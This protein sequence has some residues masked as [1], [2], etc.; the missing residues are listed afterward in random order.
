[1][2]R[3][4]DDRRW[5]AKAIELSRRCPPSDTAFSVGA[6]IVDAD[7]NE[8]ATGYSRDTDPHVHAEESALAKLPPDDP[9]LTS[10]TL[11]STLEPCTQRRSRPMPCTELILRARI[12]RIVIAWRE[13]A[14]F[15][16][17]CTG[18]ETLR[19][20]GI[21]IA[22]LPDMAPEARQVNAHLQAEIE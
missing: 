10:A 19:A 22:E 18:V 5:I 17:D 14:L 4:D 9:R 13:P 15:V 16:A 6:I 12:P 7:G 3:L 20:G 1:M 21:D 11:F 8:I 2:S